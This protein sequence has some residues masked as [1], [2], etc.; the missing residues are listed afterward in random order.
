[1]SLAVASF[2]KGS[3]TSAR[4]AC[5]R[6]RFVPSVF[7]LAL[8]LYASPCR[9]ATVTWSLGMNGNWDVAANWSSNPNLPGS[10][11]NVQNN[12]TFTITHDTGTDVINSF[13][14]QGA[15]ILSGGTLQ[16][17]TTLQVNNTFTM[18]GGTLKGATVNAGTGGQGISFADNGNNVLD[19]VT[20]N[21]NL[22]LATSTGFTQILNG[23]TLN[24]TASINNNSVLAVGNTETLAG[25]GDVLF[26]STGSSN[27]LTIEGDSTLTIGANMKIHGQN[28][29]IGGQVIANG[30]NALVNNGTISADVATGTITLTSTNSAANA[31]TNGGTLSAANGGTLALGSNNGTAN[32]TNTGNISVVDSSSAIAQNGIA[33]VGGNNQQ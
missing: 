20:A 13:L 31:I 14:S 17:S 33:I 6:D 19:G 2:R 26:G 18:D 10:T 23:L 1:M 16:V 12:T 29:T 28:G 22:D 30:T 24:G 32:I 25:S 5:W 9:A 15:F 4:N 7:F 21:A 27:R 8:L 3:N 11:D